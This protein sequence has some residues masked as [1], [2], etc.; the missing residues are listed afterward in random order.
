MIGMTKGTRIIVLCEGDTEELAVRHFIS[1][2]WRT[3]GLASIGLQAINLSG[4]LQDI[5]IKAGLYLEEPEILG[6]FTLIDLQG[7]DRVI[8]HPDD[9]LDVKIQRVLQWLRK[10]V[11]HTRIADFFPH[12]SVHEIEAWILAEGSALARRLGDP[13]IKPDPNAEQK[14]FDTPP[15]ERINK[16]FLTRKHGDRYQKIRDGRPLFAALQFQPIYESCRYFRALYDD[17]RRVAGG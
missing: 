3:D 12:V 17:L 1:R 6:A 2:Q 11:S 16:L 14:N 4:R 9:D 10:Q 15:S 5:G 8:H 13:D 7:M